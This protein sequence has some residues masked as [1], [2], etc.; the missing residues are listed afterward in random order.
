VLSNLATLKAHLLTPSLVAA[1]DYD[2]RIRAV[3]QSVLGQ[4]E[5]YTGRRFGRAVSE[6]LV[7][8]GG[9]NVLVLSRLPIESI[10]SVETRE[11]EGDAWVVQADGLDSYNPISGVVYLSHIWGD[12]RTHLRLTVTA[13]FWFESL[14][15]TAAGYP[16]AAPSGCYPLHDELRAAWLLQ[17]GLVWRTIDKLGAAIAKEGDDAPATPEL[18]PQVRATLNRYRLYAL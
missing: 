9:Q 14:E 5:A 2:A 17:C 8:P 1:T 7:L 3:G 16:S 11:R 6:Q 4:M 10:A 18:L 12:A 13:G 15:P